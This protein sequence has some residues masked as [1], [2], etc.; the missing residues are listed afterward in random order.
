MT[1]DEEAVIKAAIAYMKYSDP[2]TRK[3]IFMC[4]L[5]IAVDSLLLDRELTRELNRHDS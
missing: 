4:N 2:E 5:E 1:P 3:G